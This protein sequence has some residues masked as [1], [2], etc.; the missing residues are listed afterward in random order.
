VNVE[1]GPGVMVQ[2]AAGVLSRNRPAGAA[3][4]ALAVVGGGIKFAQGYLAV[5]AG[6]LL[7]VGAAVIKRFQ[8]ATLKLVFGLYFLYV[9]I[10]FIAAFAGVKVW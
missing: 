4:L 5:G 8:P 6:L 9:S 10:K 3:M 1:I 7:T 2:R